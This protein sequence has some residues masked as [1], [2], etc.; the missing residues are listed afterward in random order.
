[1][2]NRSIDKLMNDEVPKKLETVFHGDFHQEYTMPV[3]WVRANGG[4]A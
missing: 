3:Y 4:D 2:E 1:M